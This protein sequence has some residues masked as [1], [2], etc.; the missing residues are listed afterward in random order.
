MLTRRQKNSLLWAYRGGGLPDNIGSTAA[1][2]AAASPLIGQQVKTQQQQQKQ[3]ADLLAQSIKSGTIKPQQLS[4]T[5]LELVRPNLNKGEFGGGL[6]SDIGGVIGNLGSD[7]WSA[8]KGIPE[9]LYATGSALG[10]DLT[11]PSAWGLVPSRRPAENQFRTQVIDPMLNSY[12]YTYAGK[13]APEGSSF[14]GRLA[15][16]PLQPI[17]D[18]ATVASLGTGG[19][20]K[21]A[22]A[23][24]RAGYAGRP[25]DALVNAGRTDTRAPVILNPGQ[26]ERAG[27]AFPEVDRRYSSRPMM[28]L[29]QIAWDKVADKVTPVKEFRTNQTVKRLQRYEYARGLAAESASVRAAVTPLVGS[30]KDLTTAEATALDYALRGWN[31]PAKI[32]IAKR[33]FQDSLEGR[34][35]EGWN[36]SDFEGFFKSP[37]DA[38]AFVEYK[39]NLPEEVENFILHPTP[40]MVNAAQAT[41]EAAQEGFD[42]LGLTPEEIQDRIAE[43]NKIL[44]DYNNGRLGGEPGPDDPGIDPMP[45]DTPVGPTPEGPLPPDIR[46]LAQDHWNSLGEF[47]QLMVQRADELHQEFGDNPRHNWEDIAEWELKSGKKYDPNDEPSPEEVQSVVDDY[48]G[49]ESPEEIA[50]RNFDESE[51]TR[52]P[53]TLGDMF[54]EHKPISETDP[55]LGQML[56]EERDAWE[57]PDEPPSTGFQDFKNRIFGDDGRIF[58]EDQPEGFYIHRA[59]DLQAMDQF[60]VHWNEL[61]DEQK[62]EVDSNIA[63]IPED[64]RTH[65]QMPDNLGDMFPD[66]RDTFRDGNIPDTPE[67]FFDAWNRQDED[68]DN[69]IRG[70]GGEPDPDAPRGRPEGSMLPS[71]DLT[72]GDPWGDFIYDSLHE[73]F[74]EDPI[75]AGIMDQDTFN[76]IDEA[77]AQKMDDAGYSLRGPDG[78]DE[79]VGEDSPFAGGEHNPPPQELLDQWVHEALQEHGFARTP[80]T[81]DELAPPPDLSSPD[82]VWPEREFGGTPNTPDE[83]PPTDFEPPQPG[84]DREI[85]FHITHPD[86]VEGIKQHGLEPRIGETSSLYGQ[87]QGVFTYK[88]LN[89]SDSD[90]EAFGPEGDLAAMSEDPQA[91]AVDTTGLSRFDDPEGMNDAYPDD[92]LRHDEHIPPERV[93]HLGSIWDQASWPPREEWFGGTPNTPNEP[94][95]AAFEFPEYPIEPTYV[96]NLPAAGFQEQNPGRL[97]RMFGADESVFTRGKRK[98]PQTAL[99]ITAQNLFTK[100][101]ESYLRERPEVLASGAARVDP[102]AFVESVARRE[103]D[104][105][106]QAYNADL[107]NRLAAKGD[108]AEPIKFHTQEDVHRRLGP[109]WVLVNEEFPINWFNAETNFA[110]ET[111][112]TLEQLRLQ[113]KSSHDPEVEDIIT[114]L[115]DSHAQDFV[116]NAFNAK[117]LDGVAI[118]KEFYNYQKR[119]VTAMDPFDNKI[120][121][122][123]ARYMH[124]WRAFTL[125]YMPRWAVNTAIGSFFMNMVKGVTP[126]DYRLASQLH[127]EGVFGEPR[128][129]GVE[130]GSVT[131]ME[132]LEPAALGHLERSTGIGVTPLGER[133]VEKVQQIEDHFRRAS[134]VHSLDKVAQRRMGDM[135]QIL[136]NL[137]RRRSTF[138]DTRRPWNPRADEETLQ[139]ILDSPKAV[140]E[141]IDDLNTFAYNFAALGPYERRYV[142][143]AVPFWGWYKFISKVAY[144]LPVEYPGRTNILANIGMLGMGHEDEQLGNRPDWLHGVIPLGMEK[145]RLSY[146]STMGQNPFSSFFNPFGPQGG[147]EGAISLGQASPPIQAA[148]SAFGLDTLRGGEVP[149][150]PKQGV[151]PDFFG[152]LIDIQNGR[153]TNPAQQAGVRRFIMGLLRSAPQFR[154]GEQ[155]LAQ[156]RSVYPESVPFFDQRPM[157]TEPKDTSV[158]ANLGSIFGVAPKTYNLGGYQKGIRKRVKYAKSRNKTAMKKQRKSDKKAEK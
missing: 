133:I 91:F 16:H 8:A 75:D 131:G 73:A 147:V 9:G 85:R 40:N 132:Y 115:A 127:K 109:D 82:E 138:Y 60:G 59:R 32:Y 89:F 7:I 102:K 96:P 56:N 110:N 15:A 126:R 21:G 78:L 2:N 36:I 148:L 49:P 116:R 146:L 33:M 39:A 26:Q 145:G 67:G 27:V 84:G 29:G 118:P 19:A 92:S 35:P 14:W 13:G 152:S 107:L 22:Q 18:A 134:F 117:K 157:P 106:N 47:D 97:A 121:R 120:G 31:T 71:D 1:V 141:A 108:D 143:M 104:L 61:S 44:E 24:S 11:H 154:M 62:F 79:L 129:G 80:N 45:P 111:A 28:K 72:W 93:Q 151:A 137:E 34:L 94:P 37:E 23:A 135:G 87:E 139:A 43:S 70:L 113:G 155:Y 100:S 119:L 125:A 90:R 158:L 5:D 64:Q 41:H 68:V 86:N 52:I 99:G 51:A 136:S 123:Y 58:E 76:S 95:P 54:P 74:G 69:I 42:K 3:R 6:L 140:E 144:R 66:P 38:R 156:G 30:R 124:R 65:P 20:I 55:E 114:N 81:P 46:G 63:G 128:L 77:V 98:G 25:I 103:K 88:D 105:V 150:S 12:A 50:Q 48:A 149:I 101:P 130:L 153:E 122:A 142:R 10:H 53:N 83:P 112:N 57:G 17:L 4:S